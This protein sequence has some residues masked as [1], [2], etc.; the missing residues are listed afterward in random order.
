MAATGNLGVALV[1]KSPSGTDRE[2]LVMSVAEPLCCRRGWLGA[3]DTWCPSTTLQQSDRH[4]TNIVYMV[5]G[6]LPELWFY[7]RLDMTW[8]AFSALTLLAGRQEGHPACKKQSGGVLA[9]LSVWSEVQTCICPSWCH[10]HPLSL[11]SVKS[12]LFLSFWYRLTGTRVGGVA[13]W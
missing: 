1:C 2:I 11:A 6:W 9:W 12:R 10:C 5:T 7:V 4:H 3:G 13:Q 8:H